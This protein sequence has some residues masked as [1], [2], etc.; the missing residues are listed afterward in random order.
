M[1]LKIIVQT[2]P[3]AEHRYDTVGDWWIDIDGT[4][5]IRVSAMED[6]RHEAL[7]A[8]HETIEA[9]LCYARGITP[10]EVDK[11]DTNWKPPADD[12]SSEPGDDP[13]APYWRE[14]QFASSVE[15]DLA[16][17]LAVDWREYEASINA[18]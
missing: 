9:L 5:Q 18:L 11:F 1:A 6:Y 17:E 12:P 13:L 3:H 2:I 14:H 16:N 8:V 10:D 4:L 15:R 7:V